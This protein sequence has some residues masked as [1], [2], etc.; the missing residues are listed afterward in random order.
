MVSTPLEKDFVIM[1][2]NTEYKCINFNQDFSC[3]SVGTENEF[4]I[5]NVDPFGE[6]FELGEL[7]TCFVNP[8]YANELGKQI[9]EPMFQKCYSLLP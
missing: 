9:Q 8:L 1:L 6:C 5:Y 3:L 2:T 7:N 4:K